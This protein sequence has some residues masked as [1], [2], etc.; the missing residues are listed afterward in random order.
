[1]KSELAFGAQLQP[2]GVTFRLWAPAARRV[3]LM[4]DRPYPMRINDGGWH[5]LTIAGL[6][7][8]ALYKYR[9]DGELEVPDPASHF[10]PFDVNGP[11]EVIDHEA[12][13]WRTASWRGRPWTQAVILELHVG[14]FT[15]GGTFRSAIERLDALAEAGITAIELMPVADFAGTRNWGYDGVLWYAPDSAY[16]RPDDLRAL[17]DE[18]HA[19]GLMVYL[20]VVYNHFGPEGN[21][22]PRYAPAFFTS[23]QTPWGTA[24]DYSVPQTRA[25]AIGNALHWLACFRFDG[26]RL[27]AV[28]AIGGPGEPHLLDDLSRAVGVFAAQS[29]RAI[30]LILEN[31]DNRA[32]LLDPLVDPPQGKY[33][34]QWNDD[35][36]H[37]W[38]VLLTGEKHAYYQDYAADPGGQIARTLGCGFAYQGEASPYRG[39]RRRGEPSGLL[40]PL[41]FVNFLQNHDQIGNRP[42][43]ERLVT[44]ADD[45]PLAAALAITLLAPMPPLLFMGEEWGARTP[46]PF[47][48]DFPEPLATAV[49]KGRRAEFSEAYATLGDRIPDPLTESTFRSAV[50]DWSTRALP[51]G[52]QRLALVRELLAI[53]SREIVPYLATSTFGAAQHRGHVLQAHWRLDGRRLLLL[54]ANLSDLPAELP[55]HTLTVRSIWGAEPAGA[56]APWT[57]YWSIGGD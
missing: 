14:T 8:G 25:F 13:R 44:Q 19:R 1:M 48:C 34:A 38:H 6:E 30:H 39:G 12:F 40:S 43:G 37:A 28:H 23:A 45:P 46:F 36:H 57:V 16:G 9:I 32:S 27:D 35:Y 11:S 10:Q 7:A 2:G 18:A 53:R 15:A 17:I 56:L 41:A 22:L 21:Y 26:L 33:R 50:L 51:V 47:F 5:E 4:L 24:I 31:D 29:G 49:R 54:Q 20:D 55:L 52:R 42:L 3:E